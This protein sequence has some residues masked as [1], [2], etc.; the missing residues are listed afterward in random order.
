M[1]MEKSPK[2]GVS[3]RDDPSAGIH[4]QRLINALEANVVEADVIQGSE[5]SEQRQRNHIHYA[6]DR[7]GN[8]KAGRSHH[9]SAD[10]LDGVESQKA[11]YQEAFTSGRRVLKFMPEHDGDNGAMQA[12]EYVHKQ[13]LDKNDGYAFLR[14]SFHDAFVTKRCIAKVE[15]MDRWEVQRQPFKDLTGHQLLQLQ[16]RPEVLEIDVDGDEARQAPGQPGVPLVSGTVDVE[17]DMSYADIEL[18]Q[19]E[20]Y[21]RDPNV[22]FISEAAFAGFQED[23]ARYE[24]IE[25]GFDEDE[26]MGL[27][28]DYRFRQNEE[29]AARKAHD[30]TWSRARRHKR[31]PEQE[32]VT[33]YRHWAYLDLSRYVEPEL[34]EEYEGVRL[35]KFVWSQGRLLTLPET[36]EY[37]DDDEYIGGKTFKEEESGF[38]FFEWTQYKISHAEFGLCEAD[39]LSDIQW[40]KSN[41]RRLIIDNQAMGNTSRWKARHGFIKNPRELLDNNIG[42]VMWVKDMNALEPLETPMVRP[43]SFSLLGD[44]DGEKENRTGMSRLAKGMNSDALSHQNAADMIQR[45]TNASNRRVLRGVRDYAETFLKPMFLHIYNL[46]VKYDEQIHQLNIEG[47]QRPG[48]PNSWITRST[49]KVQVALT[50]DE[51]REQAMGLMNLHEMFSKDQDLKQMYGARQKHALV[52]DLMELMNTGDISRYLINPESQEYKA[53]VQRAQQMEQQMMQLRMK[54]VQ[55]KEADLQRKDRE[56]VIKEDRHAVDVANIASDNLRADEKLEHEMNM[57]FAELGIE[58]TQ[59]RAAKVG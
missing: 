43:E 51:G 38:P 49:L 13:F 17:Q 24:L 44:L 10:V 55:H 22:S 33:I 23:V 7:L 19:P 36:M 8:E 6:L 32:V 29:E 3:Y 41:L 14:D 12:T 56:T 28:L 31:D 52:K 11:Y 16:A 26:V 59:D 42:S 37:D 34:E 50:P 58:V 4:E 21:F 30:S 39:I 2:A 25:M 1:K 45:L 57:D 20:R 35:Y 46:G 48:R 47:E 15:W 27:N 5:V 9:I 18:V 40:T 54:E 53:V